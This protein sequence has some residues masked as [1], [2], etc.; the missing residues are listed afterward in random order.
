MQIS[1]L[2][3]CFGFGQSNKLNV[4]RKGKQML[5]FWLARHLHGIV[6]ILP[7]SFSDR[8]KLLLSYLHSLA[9]GVILV[10]D[11]F[12]KHLCDFF[13]CNYS[14]KTTIV[15]PHS[16]QTQICLYCTSFLPSMRWCCGCKKVS[17][18]RIGIFRKVN[19]SYEKSIATVLANTWKAIMCKLKIDALWFE[20]EFEFDFG[21]GQF[22]LAV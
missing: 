14:T 8:V 22:Y 11:L 21:F 19:G 13:D 1:L 2:A 16:I 18:V 20:F 15:Q 9:I 10:L 17:S 3:L 7:H 4:L 12:G 6:A 5:P